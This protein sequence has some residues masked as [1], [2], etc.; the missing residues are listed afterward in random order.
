MEYKE[1]FSCDV[2]D[3]TNDTDESCYT[4]KRRVCSVHGQPLGYHDFEEGYICDVQFCLGCACEQ[5][6]IT[7]NKYAFEKGC[8]YIATFFCIV[9]LSYN[10][11]LWL[12]NG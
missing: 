1:D 2:K 11:C 12:G 3:C 10:A 5:L 6:S 9:M 7:K 4:C 8:L